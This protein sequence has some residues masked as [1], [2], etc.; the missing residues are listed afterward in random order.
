[1][2]RRLTKEALKWLLDNISVRR[3]EDE[4]TDWPAILDKKFG[5]EKWS[6]EVG[7]P[8]RYVFDDKHGIGDAFE[9]ADPRQ[10]KNENNADASIAIPFYEKAGWGLAEVFDSRYLAYV[11]HVHMHRF[12]VHRWRFAKAKDTT[13]EDQILMHWFAGRSTVPSG[14]PAVHKSNSAG[15][16]WWLARM[17]EKA[18]KYQSREQLLS[19]FCEKVDLY[20]ETMSRSCFHNTDLMAAFM[21]ECPEPADITKAGIQKLCKMSNQEATG[22]VLDMLS[23]KELRGIVSGHVH[24]V[25]SKQQYVL[26]RGAMM[27]KRKIIRVLSLGAGVQSTVM[28]LMADRGELYDGQKPDFAIFADTKW[29]PQEVY[30]HLEWLRGKLSYEVE[31]V[32][33]GDLR[34]NVVHGLDASGHPHLEI[35]VFMTTPDGKRAGVGRRECTSSY[36][37]E[38][39]Q[40]RLREKMGLKKGEQVP[41]DTHVEMWLGI[42]TDEV[43]RQKPSQMGWITHKWPL[44]DMNMSRRDCR[45]LFDEYF[46]GRPLP[47]SACI[48]CPYHNDAEWSK[49]KTERPEQFRDAVEVDESLRRNAT[50]VGLRNIPYLHRSGR[51]LAEVVF[52]VGMTEDNGF[53]DASECDGVCG[54]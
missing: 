14:G 52:D 45:K 40:Q 30:D 1:M 9:A 19:T 2:S 8:G 38:P 15:R 3:Y 41:W 5:S 20:H 37:V 28:A 54:L 21:A 13:K 46:P 22:R 39:I 27:R 16:L 35:P 33:A 4:N 17:S 49:M 36:K 26:A 43:L 48:G 18:A 23:Y 51:P 44:I 25:M 50:K 11:T 6:V 34:N 29:E 31:I 10:F 42:S 12:N 47:R 53:D 24:H 7:T 32:E